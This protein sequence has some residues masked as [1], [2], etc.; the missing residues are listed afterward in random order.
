MSRVNSQGYSMTL[1]QHPPSIKRILRFLYLGLILECLSITSTQSWFDPSTSIADSLPGALTHLHKVGLPG[2]P[3]LLGAA[4]AG[5]VMTSIPVTVNVIANAIF[6]SLSDPQQ[7]KISQRDVARGYVDVPF[8][9]NYS[10]STNSS[11][12]YLLEFTPVGFLFD[13]VQIGGLGD[14]VQLGADGGT[15]AQRGLVLKNTPHELSFRFY[16]H[17]DV[18]AGIYPWPLRLSVRAL[19]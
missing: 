19:T 12:G 5:Q 18:Q 14:T 2:F 15:V 9:L 7:L 4:Y 6:S 11:A 16:L 10:V 17:S 1:D 3:P 13:G 8:A